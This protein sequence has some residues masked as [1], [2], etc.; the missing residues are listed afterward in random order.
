MGDETHG[1]YVSEC[2]VKNVSVFVRRQEAKTS[3][4]GDLC[5]AAVAEPRECVTW[6]VKSP[7]WHREESLDEGAY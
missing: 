6:R 4:E 2:Q 1:Q 7:G 3:P 5:R